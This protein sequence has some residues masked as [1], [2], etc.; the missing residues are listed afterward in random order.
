MKLS[1]AESE[2]PCGAHLIASVKKP[3][4]FQPSITKFKCEICDS[5]FLLISELG[6]ADK[7][8]RLTFKSRF[9]I[10]ELSQSVAEKLS[11]RGENESQR[12]RGVFKAP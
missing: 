2:C 1:T 5:R 12:K 8:G 3:K 7:D 9:E 10:L 11:A 6:R 4:P